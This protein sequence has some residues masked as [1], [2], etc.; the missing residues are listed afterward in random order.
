MALNHYKITFTAKDTVSEK[1]TL[2]VQINGDDIANDT[3]R[4][5]L[6]GKEVSEESEGS[7]V[8]Y[9]GKLVSGLD[10]RFLFRTGEEQTVYLNGKNL[11]ETDSIKIELIGKLTYDIKYEYVSATQL[12]LTI[13][14]NILEDEYDLRVTIG[15]AVGRLERELIIGDDVEKVKFGGYEFVTT[16][17]EPEDGKIKLSGYVCMNDWL[18][19]SGDITIEGDIARDTYVIL[20]DTAGSYVKFDKA[21]VKGLAKTMS[22]KNI[23]VDFGYSHNSCGNLNAAAC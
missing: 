12:K 11:A 5:T 8:V 14:K 23:G 18:C 16:S 19:F 20:N 15:D 22:E 7:T 13:P 9:Q 4:Y 10:T 21:N 17:K 2:K 6:S 1:R 3:A